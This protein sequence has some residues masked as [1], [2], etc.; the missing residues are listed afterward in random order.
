MPIRDVG[1]SYKHVSIAPISGRQA[2][3]AS[4]SAEGNYMHQEERKKP[5]FKGL[6]K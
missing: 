1:T 4:S 3:A 2:S 6:F 5:W